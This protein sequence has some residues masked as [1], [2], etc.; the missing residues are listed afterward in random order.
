MAV[1]RSSSDITNLRQRTA[2]VNFPSPLTPSR[3]ATAPSAI[4][5]QV[6]FERKVWE[7]IEEGF[8]SR[9]LCD[10][11]PFTLWDKEKQDFRHPTPIEKN[12][13]VRRYNATAI[14][15][16]W[17]VILIETAEPPSPLPLTVGC[18]AAV[19]VPAPGDGEP[20]EA[21]SPLY[22]VAHIELTT[23]YASPRIP[24]PVSSFRLRAWTYPTR[25]QREHIIKALHTL[26]SI[27]RI[28]FFWPY[29]I[30]ELHV[31]DRVYGKHTLPGKVADV[32]YFIITGKYHIGTT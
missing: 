3:A 15:V 9:H 32:R 22:A 14:S 17:P 18:V 11:A 28:S 21:T 27:R 19:F 20:N 12:W 10:S 30:A 4:P 7:T 8:G 25:Q 6:R 2:Y 23:N 31:D 26:V 24:D 29:V 5:A 16:R 13:I 1:R